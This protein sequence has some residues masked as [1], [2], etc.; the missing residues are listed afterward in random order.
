MID[1]ETR[2]KFLRQALAL[3]AAAPTLGRSLLGATAPARPRAAS[4]RLNL[5]II[6]VDGRGAANLN[7]V[8]EENIAVVCDVDRRRL[9]GA[10]R[11]Y[12]KAKAYE[13]FRRVLD[14]SELDAVVV[15]TPDHMHAIPVVWA[16]RAGLDVYCEKPLAH[17]VHEVRVIRE[18]TAKREAV[19]QMGTQ[20]HALDNYRRVVEL[21]KS[22]IVGVIRRVH[23]WQGSTR[24]S[25]GTR[26]TSA[27]P[28]RHVNYD[29]W[30]GPAPERPFHS[31]HFHFNWRYWWDFGGG[32]LADFGCHF[33]DLP[34]W[35][36]DLT[37]PTS[38][39]A[40]G[41]KEYTGDNDVPS[42][43]RVDY[44]YPARGEAPAVHLTWYHGSWTPDLFG[45]RNGV[46][47]EGENGMILAD[48][49]SRQTFLSDAEGRARP[50]EPWIPTSIGH[51][52]EWTEAVKQRAATTCN[53]DYS[54]NLA[55]AV[56]LG[57]V[58]YRAG[59]KLEWDTKAFRVTNTAAADGYLRREYRRGWEL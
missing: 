50:P 7:G 17:S 35:A 54:G 53:F 42:V 44:N 52:K 56:L 20:I 36:L 5:G 2:R 13:D 22:G 46:L 24:P 8:S 26:V 30:L 40:R 58:A 3:G 37:A 32:V 57:N 49:S 29:L 34:H 14:Q 19:T 55:E 16:L 28:P 6:G 12:P 4:S 10:K 23:V 48:Y 21:V 38:I 33:M 41:R 39:E 31:S 25:S 45:K 51:H 1:R 43:M 11:K 15:S 27:T 59:T 18:E 47:F 9:A